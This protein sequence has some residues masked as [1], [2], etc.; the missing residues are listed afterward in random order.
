MVPESVLSF[1][2]L[3]RVVDYLHTHVSKKLPVS[4]I[5]AYFYVVLAGRACLC[6]DILKHCGINHDDLNRLLKSYKRSEKTGPKVGYDL[7][8]FNS[9]AHDM[10]LNEASLSE[11]GQQVRDTLSEM[12][13]GPRRQAGA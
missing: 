1:H 8:V 3:Y 7:L 9:H 12:L 5:R 4:C 10:R 6:S 11:R 2:E 13:K